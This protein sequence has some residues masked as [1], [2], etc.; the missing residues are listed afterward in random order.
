[1]RPRQNGRHMADDIF[2]C[3]FLNENLWI[4]LKISLNFVPEV[5]INNIPALIQI[6]A[7]RR[8]G[9]KP[10][11]GTMMVSLMTHICVTRPQCVNTQSCG[12]E[13]DIDFQLYSTMNMSILPY[14]WRDSTGHF[15]FNSVHFSLLSSIRT[16]YQHRIH[17]N[18]NENI[19]IETHSTVA[20][21]F[22]Y[23]RN[24]NNGPCIDPSWTPKVTVR[25]A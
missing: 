16:W 13:I 10:L 7:W 17:F 3:I 5:R 20:R 22:T 12:F 15:F 9:D 25:M 24:I 2:K 11:S 4:S 18:T 23:M 1:M 14:R 6:M 21:S 8:S 19:L